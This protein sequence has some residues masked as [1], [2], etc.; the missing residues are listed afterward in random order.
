MRTHTSVSYILISYITNGSFK[1]NFFVGSLYFENAYQDGPYAG[2]S[3][4]LL[5][6]LQEEVH[7]ESAFEKTSTDSWAWEALQ[8]PT[9][10]LQVQILHWYYWIFHEGPNVTEHCTS[11]IE[12]HFLCLLLFYFTVWTLSSHLTFFLIWIGRLDFIC[13][14]FPPKSP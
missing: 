10:W 5:W 9:L 4:V 2:R 12:N 3:I 7:K 1:Q 11:K 14:I 8:M 13:T 6:Y